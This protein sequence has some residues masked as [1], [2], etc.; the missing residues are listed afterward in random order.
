MAK[1]EKQYLR[2]LLPN[3]YT[4]Q[5]E[6]KPR[7]SLIQ[8]KADNLMLRCQV[9]FLSGELGGSTLIVCG[10]RCLCNGLGQNKC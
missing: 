8:F 9:W 6:I 7:C 2:M 5:I 1:A 3:I 4:K 10:V